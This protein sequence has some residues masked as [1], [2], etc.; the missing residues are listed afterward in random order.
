MITVLD[1]QNKSAKW[2]AKNPQAHLDAVRL[3]IGL[4]WGAC[5]VVRLFPSH[6]S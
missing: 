3:Q 1:R 4:R 6:K 5:N 2:A